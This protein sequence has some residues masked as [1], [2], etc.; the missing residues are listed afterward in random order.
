LDRLSLSDFGKPDFFFF[1][2]KPTEV[3]LDAHP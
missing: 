3:L 2:L 1:M